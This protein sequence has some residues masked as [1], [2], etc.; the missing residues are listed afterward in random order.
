MLFEKTY[1][2]LLIGR[3]DRPGPEPTHIGHGLIGPRAFSDQK[4]RRHRARP[5]QARGAVHPDRFPC[6]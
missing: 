2:I 6:G 1:G 5:P 3:F 4:Y